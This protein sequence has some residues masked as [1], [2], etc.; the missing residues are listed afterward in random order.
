MFTT[1]TH[2]DRNVLRAVAAGRCELSGRSLLVDGI[3]CCDQFVGSRLAE[4]GLITA[5]PGRA[6]LTDTGA[7]VLA[8]AA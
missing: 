4:A 3:G 6:S 7:A 1:L 8:A 2:R 5:L